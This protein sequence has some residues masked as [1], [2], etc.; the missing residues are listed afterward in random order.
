MKIFLLFL[1]LSLAVVHCDGRICSVSKEFQVKQPQVLSGTFKD[2]AQLPLPGL[3]VEL[4][5]NNKVI[6]QFRTDNDGHYDFGTVAPGKY[7]IRIKHGNEDFCAPKIKCNKQ[8][9]NVSAVLPV[10]PKN[11]IKVQLD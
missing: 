11:E 7:R 6:Q 10:N 2:P 4:L 8:G 3:E 5:F 1:I 9:C